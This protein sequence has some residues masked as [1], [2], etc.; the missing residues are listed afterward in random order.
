MRHFALWSPRIS[1]RT[2]FS[3]LAILL[4]AQ[5]VFWVAFKGEEAVMDLLVFSLLAASPLLV[6][7]T[8]EPEPRPE[9]VSGHRGSR[10]LTLRFPFIAGGSSGVVF[11]LVCLGSTIGMFVLI[12]GLVSGGQVWLG[13]D[14]PVQ[15]ILGALYA[16]VYVLLPV[17]L[18]SPWLGDWR[19]RVLAMATSASF[20]WILPLVFPVG[21]HDPHKWTELGSPL[22]MISTVLGDGTVIHYARDDFRALVGLAAAGVLLNSRRVV[23]R[24]RELRKAANAAP[25]GAPPSSEAHVASAQSR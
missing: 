21:P 17:G 10:A 13:D 14:D 8:V 18:F 6:W 19:V 5:A 3:L 23:R 24:W 16:C 4:I 7:F 15:L 20:Y 22:K 11:L 2:R 12:L 9:L 25:I 1:S